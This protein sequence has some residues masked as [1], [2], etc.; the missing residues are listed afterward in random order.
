MHSKINSSFG[1][2][3]TKQVGHLHKTDSSTFMMSMIEPGQYEFREYTHS[4]IGATTLMSNILIDDYE[5]LEFWNDGSTLDFIV[6]YHMSTQEIRILNLRQQGTKW[7]KFISIYLITNFRYYQNEYKVVKSRILLHDTIKAKC[8]KTDTYQSKGVYEIA[9]GGSFESDADLNI[10][11]FYAARFNTKANFT[12]NYYESESLD[13]SEQLIDIFID[14]E[15]ERIY[16]VLDVNTNKYHERTIYSPGDLPSFTT[17]NI[18]IV[19]LSFEFG[20]RLWVTLVGDIENI[21]YFSGLSMYNN[22][23]Y[24][25]IT[26][27]TTVYSND[28][29][30]TDII[31]SKIRSDNGYVVNTQ[32]LGSPSDDKA[33]DITATTA[34]IYIL[35]IIGDQFLPHYDPAKIWQTYGGAGKTNLAVLLIRDSDSTL[36]DIEGYD[37]TTVEDPSPI[38]FSVSLS[39][40]GREFIFYSPSPQDPINGLWMTKFT[41]SSKVFIDDTPG[42]W[43]DTTNWDRCNANDPS[44]C[45]TCNASKMLYG[46]K[47][48]A[49]CPD[50]SFQASDSSG[51]LI[52]VCKPCHF[53]CKTC[54]GPR[55][56]Q[57]VTCCSGGSWG[58]DYDRDPNNGKC[59]WQSGKVESN[60]KCLD[61]CDT[62]LRGWYQD[63][64]LTDWPSDSYRYFDWGQAGSSQEYSFVDPLSA[65]MWFD[66]NHHLLFTKDGKG[67]V[68]DG[69]TDLIAIPTEYTLSFWIKPLGS[70]IS[71][72]RDSYVLNLFDVIKVYITTANKV[73]YSVGDDGSAIQ[74]TYDSANDTLD[75]TQWNYVAVTLKQLKGSANQEV[76]IQLSIASGRTGT[77]LDAGSNTVSLPPFNSFSKTIILGGDSISTPKSFGG[78][79]KDVKFFKK[80]HSFDQLAVDQLK[81]YKEYAYDDPNLIVHW[82]LNESY[83]STDNIY[84]INDY[85]L[86]RN[87][88]TVHLLSNPL[89]PSFVQDALIALNLCYYHD[90]A[91]CMTI[92]KSDGRLAPFSYAA[93]RYS[94][95]PSMNIDDSSLIIT[96]GDELTFCPKRGCSNAEAILYRKYDSWAE[97]DYTPLPTD[98]LREGTHYYL[99]YYSG[100]VEATFPLAQ[101][102]IAAMIDKISPS[103][104]TSFRTTGVVEDW[105]FSGGDQA[106]GDTIMFS[107]DWGIILYIINYLSFVK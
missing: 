6:A 75:I 4:P 80:F 105:D 47:C 36:I 29:T 106:F 2:P 28:E 35:S 32:I 104:Y 84:T 42:V 38:A 17:P 71:Y 90:V 103:E 46:N 9:F 41:D 27:H 77:L 52:E 72:G 83:D 44:M 60:G 99:W 78:Y 8:I 91:D 45:M 23:I 69:P 12:L 58:T 21:N 43:T 89:Y 55:L 88:K 50:S 97:D 64:C 86:S 57:W 66:L 20:T 31:Y 63:Y 3:T 40:G 16:V 81:L 100:E 51:S 95:A 92:D 85:S 13:V 30:Q 67:I 98:G 54:L 70:F 76:F 107:E 87:S 33:L 1:I 26:S 59:N 79:L 68:V 10:L 56:D 37:M 15:N 74:P 5:I 22:H 53:S 101:I 19:A 82:K 49:S 73:R 94:Y 65:T 11:D 7:V 14:S 96:N 18:A 25:V 48:A 24:L 34:G 102:Y 61:K 93:W 39:T 62:G